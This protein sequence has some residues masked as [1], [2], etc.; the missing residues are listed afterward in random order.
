VVAAEGSVLHILPE[1]NNVWGVT[2]LDNLLY[3][4]RQQLSEHI[5][6][7]D[8]QSYRIQRCLKVQGLRT[9]AD[10]TSC[11]HNCC[12]Y[13]SGHTDKCVHR[14][15]L[16]N[17]DVTK[18]PVNDVSGC[19]SVT[20]THSVLV[21]CYEVRKIKEFTTHGNLLRQLELPQDVMTPCHAVQLSSGEFITCHGRTGDSLHRVCVV[22][23][24]GQ[25][26]KS[27]G[28]TRGARNHQMDSPTHLAVDRNGFVFVVDRNNCRV[29][30]LSPE[31]TSV[32][33]I[34]SQDRLQWKPQRLFLD[35]DRRRLYIAENQWQQSEF[36]AGRVVVI[37]I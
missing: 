13:I 31:L 30:L 35:S 32:P 1:G 24:N 25:V 20:E 15:A 26:V 6:V 10:I 21:S 16:P 29:L 2:A 12:L 33:K 9:K 17:V 5:E 19:L 36:S 11:A 14:V 34:V 4:L 23:S 18:W 37:S 28:G 22:R 7:Y 3:V 8:T 27:Y